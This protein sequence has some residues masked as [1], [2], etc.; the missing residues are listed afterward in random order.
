MQ[1]TKN[2]KKP[3][4]LNYIDNSIENV[5]RLMANGLHSLTSPCFRILPN[6]KLGPA[7]GGIKFKLY[8]TTTQPHL[9]KGVERTYS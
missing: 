5:S 4:I 8:G 7:L 6:L 2:D 1:Q 9:P 3:P